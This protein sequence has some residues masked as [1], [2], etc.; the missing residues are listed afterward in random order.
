M[1]Q[2]YLYTRNLI[3]RTGFLLVI[4]AGSIIVNPMNAYACS[5]VGPQTPN[6]KFAQSEAVFLGR[7]TSSV[8]DTPD[9]EFERRV[10]LFQIEDS[11]KGIE[12]DMA[13]VYTGDDENSCAEY[14]E[15]E[16]SYLVYA[17][18]RF[19]SSP[20]DLWTNICKYN[21]PVEDAAEDLTYLRANHETINQIRILFAF[22]VSFLE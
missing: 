10:V 9:G 13:T 18:V 11:W 12:V 5:C 8:L 21:E 19:E 2:T 20:D 6:E 15:V 4:M 1:R 3:I 14:F 17:S 16:Q 7:V 22:I